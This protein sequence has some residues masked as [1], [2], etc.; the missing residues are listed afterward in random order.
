MN[1]RVVILIPAFNEAE[2]IGAVVSTVS[3]FGEVIVVNDGS[4]DDT[5]YV[6]RSV[7]AVVVSHEA[8]RGYDYALATGLARAVAENFDFAITVDGD[9]QHDP[10]RIQDFINEL[11]YG[12]DVVIGIRDRFQRISE[13]VFAGMTKILWGISDPL[14]GMKGYR[15]SKLNASGGLC[16]YRSIGTEIVIRAARSGWSI[17][18]VSVK[19]RDRNG[20]SRFGAG[21]LANWLIFRAMG[22]GLF[23]AKA[24]APKAEV[25]V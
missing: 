2:I 19:T 5:E 3:L 11:L 14:C 23:R 4:T 12:A 20:R 16:S 8:N 9:G 6:A 24:Y 18:Q 17:R 22:L 25:V 1:V 21:F 7:G 10:E 15:L 13:R